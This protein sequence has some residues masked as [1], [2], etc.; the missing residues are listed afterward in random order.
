MSVVGAFLVGS[1]DD[2]ISNQ[3]RFFNRASNGASITFL[4]CCALMFLLSL[5]RRAASTNT[6]ETVKY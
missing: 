4:S 1:L 2:R 3:Q 6:V 5:R